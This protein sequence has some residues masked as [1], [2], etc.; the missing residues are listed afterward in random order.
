MN[1]AIDCT[2]LQSGHR[3][4][5]V[6][7]YTKLLIEALQ[8]YESHNSYYFFTRGQ[9]IPKNT[10]L[11]HYPYFDPYFVTL[12]LFYTKPTIV[13]VHD[14]IPLVFPEHFLSG[15]RG[16]LTWHYQRTRLASAAR[17]LADS[18][19]SKSDIERIASISASRIDVIPLAP[20]SIFGQ[21]SDKTLLKKVKD[22]YHLP[23]RFLLY[24]GDINWNK[25]II[26]MLEAF[27]RVKRQ[28]SRVTLVLVGKAFL[29]M[30]IPEARRIK[31]F[32]EQNH[33][34]DSVVYLGGVPSED[35]V[36]IY[37]LAMVYVQPS[38][39]EGFGLPVLE[40]MAC[41]VPVVV[42]R[43]SSLEEIRGP[44]ISVDPNDHGD[45]ARGIMEALGLNG[46][47]RKRLV[48]GQFKWVKQYSWQRVAGE[49]IS[50]YEKALR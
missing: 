18:R 26:G 44:A 31:S 35:L 49:T 42:S 19:A 1:I 5:G 21:I 7:M 38:L 50:S 29:D 37:N 4:R 34:E 39:Y 33:L 43:S 17:I 36:A 2:P 15:V 48:G 46:L 9:N 32:I 12:P 14:L 25:N 11:I 45:V 10:E 27:Q 47:A 28:A 3:D 23:D 41:G 24:V 20:A 30:N 40:A 6:G 22:H 13:T 8:K 16:T